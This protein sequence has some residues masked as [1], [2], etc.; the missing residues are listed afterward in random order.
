M[1]LDVGGKWKRRVNFVVWGL[2]LDIEKDCVVID[3]DKGYCSVKSWEEYKSFICVKFEIYIRYL[4][5]D[6]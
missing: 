5:G 3:Y 1:K 6:V 4:C 2:R